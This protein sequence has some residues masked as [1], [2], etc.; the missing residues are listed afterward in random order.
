MSQLQQDLL[1]GE[2]QR[3]HLIGVAGS[4]MSGLALLL[5]G[6][7]P[8]LWA[9]GIQGFSPVLVVLWLALSLRYAYL[10]RYLKP[11]P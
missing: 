9:F 3:I 1:S 8:L 4:G 11:Q 5:L 10:I 7:C 6:V 2:P